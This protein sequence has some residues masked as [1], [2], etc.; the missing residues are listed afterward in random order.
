MIDADPANGP[1]RGL[2]L[3]WDLCKYKEELGAKATQKDRSVSC[4]LI[5]KERR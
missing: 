4:R 2:L 1:V 5:L 3:D